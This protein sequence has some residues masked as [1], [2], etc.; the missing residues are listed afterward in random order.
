M[1][2]KTEKFNCS[3]CLK[4]I[5]KGQEI[6]ITCKCNHVIIL[7]DECIFK[8]KECI[9][10]G[11]N[12]PKTSESKCNIDCPTNYHCTHR[13]HLCKKYI[14]NIKNCNKHCNID[15]P[16]NE[17]K[18]CN[19]CKIQNNKILRCEHHI[20]SDTYIIMYDNTAKMVDSK[21]CKDCY[22]KNNEY[23]QNC[24]DVNSCDNNNCDNILS[25]CEECYNNCNCPECGYKLNFMDIIADNLKR[26]ILSQ[27]TK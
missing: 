15:T 24:K 23:Q 1:E 22:K 9:K 20:Y 10:C 11:Q 2:N 27:N 8:I 12:I 18:N 6:K 5:K 7:D 3:I 21:D 4:E 26:F 16:I 19:D 17:I 25:Y 13:C 14:D